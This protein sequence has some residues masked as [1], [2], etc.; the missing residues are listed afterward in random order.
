MNTEFLPEADAEFREAVRYYEEE[1]PG[2][3]HGL[4]RRGASDD[5]LDRSEPERCRSRW[6]WL[7]EEGSAPFPLGRPLLS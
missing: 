2:V 6:Q 1:A 4:C 5:L 3:G 7:E